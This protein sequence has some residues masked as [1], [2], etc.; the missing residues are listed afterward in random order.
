MLVTFGGCKLAHAHKRPK[1]YN[2]DS[3]GVQETRYRTDKA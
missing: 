2:H 1:T 3:V